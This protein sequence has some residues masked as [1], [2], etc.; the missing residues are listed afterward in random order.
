MKKLIL[1]FLVIVQIFA[2]A[3]TIDWISYPIDGFNAARGGAFLLYRNPSN[4]F[5]N[6]STLVFSRTMGFNLSTGIMAFGRKAVNLGGYYKVYKG[7]T[8]FGGFVYDGVSGFEKT[9]VDGSRSGIDFS[10]SRFLFAGGFSFRFGRAPVSTSIMLKYITED[11]YEDSA[12]GYG[13]K[14][15]ISGFT[16]FIN[17]GLFM[18]NIV[19]VISWNDYEDTYPINFGLSLEK[20]INR[21]GI[22]TVIE[23]DFNFN[24]SYRL[25]V[26]Y[27]LNKNTQLGL[28]TMNGNISLGIKYIYKGIGINY[29]LQIEKGFLGI[30]NMLSFSYLK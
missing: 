13:L 9:Y 10:I 29:A 12:S 1:F 30:N 21:I 11:L 25:G 4:L 20:Y 3:E 7:L 26:N 15:N 22:A 23:S 28:G 24:L 16:R 19:Q 18:D 14:I 6:P 8:A 17:F 5:Y 27:I 2:M